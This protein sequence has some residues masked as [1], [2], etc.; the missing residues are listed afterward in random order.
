MGGIGAFKYAK[1]PQESHA[2]RDSAEVIVEG[3][4]EA[5]LPLANFGTVQFGRVQA[6]GTSLWDLDPT[7]IDMTVPDGE[8]VR[9]ATSPLTDG[10]DSR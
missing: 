1:P 4:D 9:A 8:N 6:D 7:M 10:R 5:N 2:L 3:H